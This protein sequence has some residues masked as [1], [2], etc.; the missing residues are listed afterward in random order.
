MWSLAI[1]EQFYIFWPLI[2]LCIYKFRLKFIY[3]LILLISVS[4]VLNFYDVY[5]N[6]IAAYYSP[7]GRS[8]ELLVGACLAYFTTSKYQF[9]NNYKNSQSIIG[10]TLIIIGLFLARPQNLPGTMALFPTLGTFF[11]ISAGPTG[12]INRYILSI[13][14]LV[15]V[16]LISYPLYLWHW[17]LMSFSHIILGKLPHIIAIGCILLSILAA[18]L[19]FIYIEKPIRTS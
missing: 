16:G 3:I 17:P 1:E 18:Y 4:F 19:T 6:N 12:I 7:L 15:W 8:W 2:I 14:P 10:F 9:L 13:R 11:L 5:K